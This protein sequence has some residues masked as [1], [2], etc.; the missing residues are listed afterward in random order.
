M[1]RILGGKVLETERGGPAGG[2]A[3]LS[4]DARRLLQ[5]FDR[6]QNE[7]AEFSRRSFRKAVKR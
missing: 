7:V 2:G 3:R 1:E 4:P 5:I 6:W